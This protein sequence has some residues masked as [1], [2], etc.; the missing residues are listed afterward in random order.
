MSA[1]EHVLSGKRPI[2]HLTETGSRW[3]PRAVFRGSASSAYGKE[4][5]WSAETKIQ[6]YL[7]GK[8]FSRNQLMND[9]AE[10]YLDRSAD[11]ADILHE[12]SCHGRARV[13]S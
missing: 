9:N 10:W 4:L 7:T 1:G 12:Y 11:T 3:L 2:P 13:D 8:V 5:R 6:P